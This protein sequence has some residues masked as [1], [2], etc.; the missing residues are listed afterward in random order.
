MEL[1][2][3]LEVGERLFKK[4]GH[5][6]RSWPQVETLRNQ[7][8]AVMLIGTETSIDGIIAMKDEIRPEAKGVINELHRV[9]IKVIMLTGDNEVMARA[10]AKEVGIDDFRADLKPEGKVAAVRELA[11]KYG[12]VGHG[13]RWHKRCSGSGTGNGRNSDGNGRYRRGY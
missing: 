5:E 7:G 8:K 1:K 13:R 10:I 3:G 9:G 6:I 11:E 12:A 4:L 2:Q